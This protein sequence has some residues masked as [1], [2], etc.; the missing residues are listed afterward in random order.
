M[1]N[2]VSP[3]P[4]KILVDQSTDRV[5]WIGPYSYIVPVIDPTLNYRIV[6][7]ITDE[8]YKEYTQFR[9]FFDIAAQTFKVADLAFEN[10]EKQEKAILLRLKCQT[11]IALNNAFNFYS[12]KMNIKNQNYLESIDDYTKDDWAKIYEEI[13]K[14][15]KKLADKLL[16]FKITEHKK[17]NFLIESSRFK[18]IEQ[19]IKAKTINELKFVYDT[20]NIKVFNTNP[21]TKIF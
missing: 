9:L 7:N 14:C 16:D 20:T 17:L 15:P 3:T 8:L 2:N 1:T 5:I 12:E 18:M 21:Q 11:F 13:F 10:I 4:N 19:I 6:G